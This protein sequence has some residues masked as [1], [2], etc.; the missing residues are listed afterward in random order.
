MIRQRQS[1]DSSEMGT[2]H[3][4]ESEFEQEY[5]LYSSTWDNSK[6]FLVVFFQIFVTQL[7]QKNDFNWS[8]AKVKVNCPL[9]VGSRFLTIAEIVNGFFLSWGGQTTPQGARG[10]LWPPLRGNWGW[11][12]PPTWPQEVAQPP[13][14]AKH[15]NKF[16]CITPYQPLGWPKPPPWLSQGGRPPPSTLSLWKY[17][18]TKCN[19]LHQL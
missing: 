6:L 4:Y 12:A 14:R 9:L 5:A 1:F 11:P 2:L 17:N 10:W 7:T 16:F 3:N 13:F 18:G 8:A 19:A 15:E